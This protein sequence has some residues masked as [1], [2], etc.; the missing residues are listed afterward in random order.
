MKARAVKP[1]EC[2]CR[3]GTLRTLFPAELER[4][5]QKERSKY[6]DNELR[7]C[8]SYCS[9]VFALPGGDLVRLRDSARW[10]ITRPERRPRGSGRS[11]SRR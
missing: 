11:V 10:K 4:V 1:G 7:I 9:D 3:K 5:P 2:G 8:G 6:P